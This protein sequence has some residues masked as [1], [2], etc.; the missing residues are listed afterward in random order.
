MTLGGWS[1]DAFTREGSRTDV[2]VPIEEAQLA[3]VLASREGLAH[4]DAR[5]AGALDHLFH[6][7][8]ENDEKGVPVVTLH[9]RL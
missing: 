9:A 8:T 5:L 1:L 2:L 6:L 3:E 4:D 7:A